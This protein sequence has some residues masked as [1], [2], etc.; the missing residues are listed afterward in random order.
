M[1]LLGGLHDGRWRRFEKAPDVAMMAEQLLDLA[2]QVGV[3]AALRV[4]VRLALGD[5]DQLQGLEKN[6][7]RAGLS[8][9]S[10]P[11]LPAADRPIRQCEECGPTPPSIAAILFLGRHP[12]G[13]NCGSS[14][15]AM[16]PRPC[17]SPIP[18]G[19]SERYA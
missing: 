6:R 15:V 16:Q 1:Q 11:R 13:P 3:A 19:S 17:V 8:A 12:G 4:E 18:L 14:Q 5:R 9:C 2:A 10:C 7:L